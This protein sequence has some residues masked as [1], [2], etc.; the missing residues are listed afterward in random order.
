MNTTKVIAPQTQLFLP[1]RVITLIDLVR[2][3]IRSDEPSVLVQ[4]FA[5]GNTYIKAVVDITRLQP[6]QDYF[7]RE[8]TAAERIECLSD[9]V[10]EELSSIREGTRCE[11]DYI[12]VLDDTLQIAGFGPEWTSSPSICWAI[13]GNIPRCQ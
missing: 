9:A 7:Q 2:G 4:R 1:V 6:T 13:Y 11:I 12:K 8:S 5:S 3:A 10:L